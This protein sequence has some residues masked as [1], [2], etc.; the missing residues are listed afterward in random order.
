MPSCRRRSTSSSTSPGGRARITGERGE[1]R[2]TGRGA[3]G[4]T[5]II[6]VTIQTFPFALDG[7]PGAGQPQSSERSPSSPTRPT[8]R[9]PARRSKQTAARCS[10]PSRSRKRRQVRRRGA[11]ASRRWR[12]GSGRRTSASSPSPPRRRPRPWSCSGTTG[13]D[14]LPHPFHLYSMQQ[15]IEEGFILDV[16]RNYTPY[17]TG[18][19]TG[20]RR[21]ANCDDAGQWTK[22][23]GDEVGDALGQLHP[24]TSARR[25][26]SSSS[27]SAPTW[28]AA[29]RAGQGDGR[30]LVAQGGGALQAGL[31]QVRCA[32]RATPMSRRWWRS[33]A[34]S[35]TRRAARRR[36]PKPSM[37]PGLKGRDLRE[38]FATDEYQT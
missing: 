7:D 32:S 35:P 3:A 37:N 11:A 1:V 27:T 10:R 29:G 30:H 38:A 13:V 9:R 33:P 18:V 2:P 16:L 20:P 23:D 28:L 36:S 15:A 8:P 26:R 5:P 12:R 17:K 25:C 21:H 34:R 22:R 31:R 24:T 4:G 6:I 14:G 19:P